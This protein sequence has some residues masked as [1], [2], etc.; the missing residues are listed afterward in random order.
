[1]TIPL[2][3]ARRTG[4]V[5]SSLQEPST[6]E[7]GTDIYIEFHT[8]VGNGEFTGLTHHEETDHPK[9]SW[10]KYPV[11]AKSAMQPQITVAL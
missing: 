11:Q 2:M 3:R 4:N 5:Q 7:A 1:M 6:L 8:R 10:R 9:F